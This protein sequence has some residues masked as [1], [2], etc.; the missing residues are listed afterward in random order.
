MVQRPY[1]KFNQAAF[2]L[3]KEWFQI[4]T[5]GNPHLQGNFQGYDSLDLNM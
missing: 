1:F 3:N 2:T 4:L 5:Q